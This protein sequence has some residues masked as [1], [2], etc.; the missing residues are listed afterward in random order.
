MAHRHQ[1]QVLRLVQM[2]DHTHHSSIAKSKKQF[3]DFN[4]DYTSVFAK[5]YNRAYGLGGA[6]FETPFGSAL[7]RSDKDV[8]SNLIYLDNNPVERKLV[9]KA[10]QYRWN[11]LA[12]ANSP[13]PFS[14][15][16]VLREASMPLRRALDRIRDLHT[17]EQ[18]TTYPILNNLLDAIPTN[19]EKEQL[20]DF[21][22]ST[23]SVLDNQ[24]V[25]RY[26]GSYE[27]ELIAAHSTTGSE[28]DISEGFIG[29]SDKLYARFTNILL[30]SQS[31]EDIHNILTLPE[32]EKRRLYHFLQKETHAPQKQIAAFLHL[33][34]G[35]KSLIYNE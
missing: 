6:V 27:Q 9:E 8:R 14:D 16:I 5:E 23:Y 30:D 10:E 19:K 1:I 34:R 25:F 29:K 22:V 15:K 35:G 3:A 18:Y 24:T 11:Y 12:Y 20:T 7:K 32:D 26:F 13:H 4:R 21:I 17:R 2:P 33:S 31:F 28:H